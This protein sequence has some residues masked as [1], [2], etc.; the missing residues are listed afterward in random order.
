M[1]PINIATEAANAKMLLLFFMI[2]R[3]P[4]NKGENGWH[5]DQRCHGCAE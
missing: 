3:P 2:Q 4:V 1:N 5:E